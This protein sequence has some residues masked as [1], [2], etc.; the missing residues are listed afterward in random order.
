[1]E[2]EVLKQAETNLIWD[3]FEEKDILMFSDADVSVMYPVISKKLL[4][5]GLNWLIERLAFVEFYEHVEELI[6]G[7]LLLVVLI[8]VS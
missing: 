7:S 3:L 5:S 2:Q 8:V 6:Q 4:Y 1:M